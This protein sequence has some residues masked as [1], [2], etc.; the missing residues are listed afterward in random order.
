MYL[1][2]SLQ[3]KLAVSKLG[4]L[5]MISSGHYLQRHAQAVRQPQDIV[6]SPGECTNFTVPRPGMV[7]RGGDG[8]V[9]G[10][11]TSDWETQPTLEIPKGGSHLYSGLFLFSVSVRHWPL[12]FAPQWPD[13][14]ESQEQESTLVQGE[15]GKVQKTAVGGWRGSGNTQHRPQLFLLHCVI[16][17]MIRLLCSQNSS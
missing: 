10:A 2:R 14:S 5:R 4:N 9:T 1:S 7:T 12:A 13:P 16:L 11:V 8:A 15:Q 3:E 17:T 6:R